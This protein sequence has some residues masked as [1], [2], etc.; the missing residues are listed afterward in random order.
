MATGTRLMQEISDQFLNCKICFESFREPKTLACLHTFCLDC[1]QQQYEQEVSSRSSRFSLYTSRSITCPLCRKK[2]ELPAGGVRRLPDNFLVCNLNQVLAK[3]TVSRVPPCDICASVRGRSVDAC[4]KCLDCTKLL[5]KECVDLHL[6]TK[7]TQQHSIIDLEGEKDIVCKVHS[8]ET[9]KF[10]CEPCGSCI[11]VVCAFQEHKDHD[12]L[13]FSDSFAK[14]RGDLESLL[15]Q[16]KTRAQEVSSRLSVIDKY[17]TVVKGVRDTIR[18]L[19][20]SSIAKVRAKERE[21][22]KR[23]DDLYGGEVQAFVDS[24]PAL[25]ENLDELQN[26]VQFT[27][28]MLR[29]KSVELLLMK[30]DIEVKMAQLLGPELQKIPSDPALY[31]IRFEPGDVVLGKLSFSGDETNDRLFQDEDNDDI[32]K[33][34]KK[35]QNRSTIPG[36]SQENVRN[37]AEADLNFKSTSSSRNGPDVVTD[38][39]Q[40]EKAR[41]QEMSTQVPKTIGDTTSKSQFKD[42]RNNTEK[43]FDTSNNRL[44]GD[45]FDTT[46]SIKDYSLGKNDLDGD[47]PKSRTRT[48]TF[49]SMGQSGVSSTYLPES[50]SSPGTDS[51]AMTRTQRR[52]ER[53]ARRKLLSEAGPDRG[54]APDLVP[55][56]IPGPPPRSPIS[57]TNTS[58]AFVYTPGRTIRSRKIQTEI[59]ALDIQ[60]GASNTDREFVQTMLQAELV[61]EKMRQEKEELTPFSSRLRDR[62]KKVRTADI[63]VMTAFEVRIVPEMVDKE[64]ASEA[65]QQKDAGMQVFSESCTN[66]TQT[67]VVRLENSGMCTDREGQTEKG[68]STLNIEL[69]DKETCTTQVMNETKATWTEGVATSDRATATMVIK[70]QHRAVGTIPQSTGVKGCQANPQVSVMYTNTPVVAS[71]DLECQVTPQ[72]SDMATMPDPDLKAESIRRDAQADSLNVTDS[73]SDFLT[74]PQSPL[75]K[76]TSTVTCDRA[77]DAIHIQTFNKFTETLAVKTVTSS[78]ETPTAKVVDRDMGTEDIKTLDQWTE[79]YTP[80]M[81]NTGVTPPRPDTL[82]VGVS[83]TVVLTD[84][85]ATCTDIKSFRDTQTET[86]LVVCDGETL[87]DP[88]GQSDAQ[89]SVE[90][91]TQSRQCETELVETADETSMTEYFNPWEAIDTIAQA[92]QCDTAILKTKETNTAQLKRKNKEAQTCS[93]PSL[94]PECGM[95]DKDSNKSENTG[96][97][98]FSDLQASKAFKDSSTMPQPQVTQDVGTMAISCNACNHDYQEMAIQTFQPQLY[99]KASATSFDLNENF[100]ARALSR[101]YHDVA[102]STDSLPFIGLLSEIDVDELIVLSDSAPELVSAS[103]DSAYMGERVIMVDDETSTDFPQ[104]VETGTQTF[105]A[106]PS[107]EESGEACTTE[108]DISGKEIDQC[109]EAL[110][111]ACF[112]KDNE[113]NGSHTGNSSICNSLSC[114]SRQD[115]HLVSIGVNT[116]PKVTFEKETCM[117]AEYLLTKNKM[118]FYT[119]KGTSTLNRVRIV[120]VRSPGMGKKTKSVDKIT[121]TSRVEQRE[122]A[123]ETEAQQVDG[124]ITE[125]ISKLRNV[126]ARLNSPNGSPNSPTIV[127]STKTGSNSVAGNEAFFGKTFGTGEQANTLHDESENTRQANVKNLLDK[128]N[129][130]LRR[131]DPSPSRKPQPITTLKGRNSSAPTSIEHNELSSCQKV[132]ASEFV[133][134]DTNA[135]NP[136]PDSAFSSKSLPRGFTSERRCGTVKMGS[137]PLSPPRLPLNRYNSAPGKIATVPSQTLLIKSSSAECK[138]GRSP[139]PRLPESS[140]EIS[141]RAIAPSVGNNVDNSSARPQAFDNKASPECSSSLAANAVGTKLQ[142]RHPLPSITETRTPSSCSDNSTS[143]LHSLG[144]VTSKHQPSGSAADEKHSSGAKKKSLNGTQPPSSINVQ[145]SSTSHLGPK[146]PRVSPKRMANISIGAPNVPSKTASQKVKDAPKSPSPRAKFSMQESTKPSSPKPTTPDVKKRNTKDQSSISSTS[147]SSGLSTNHPATTDPKRLSVQSSASSA[148]SRS[149]SGSNLLSVSMAESSSDTGSTSSRRSSKEKIKSSPSKDK[150]KNSASTETIQSNASNE[151]SDGTKPKK[152]GGI[153]FMQRF[154]SKKK[155]SSEG[156]KE[157]VVVNTKLC[158][159]TAD[160]VAALTTLPGPVAAAPTESYAHVPL[161]HPPHHYIPQLEVK[162]QSPV[163]KPSAFVYVNQRLIS[164]QQDNVEEKKANRKGKAKS[165]NILVAHKQAMLANKEDSRDKSTDTIKDLPRGEQTKGTVASDTKTVTD[166]AKSDTACSGVETSLKKDSRYASKETGGNPQVVKTDDAEKEKENPLL[167]SGK[168]AKEISK[169]K[170][171]AKK[172]EVKSA[173]SWIRGRGDKSG[174]K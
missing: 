149:P 108:N 146:S 45:S 142:K 110:T 6:G 49:A 97:T 64:T 137:Q 90:V 67:P 32:A 9:V 11:C 39:S 59:S 22:M 167:V 58:G 103:G 14:Y 60:A 134:D 87:T 156:K 68:T 151:T 23:I 20:I 81:I 44:H 31:D 123:V 169:T 17:E 8:E 107:K 15:G 63:G 126:S 92:S 121:M 33:L 21:L 3:R 161:Q 113:N 140:S 124:K 16:C 148:H 150:I 75:P 36:Q 99:D 122:V 138:L 128:T 153:G 26:T 38:C 41:T 168:E 18:D 93:D 139:S 71:V 84:D 125:C 85:Q 120:H 158:P 173:S 135:P 51:V 46:S 172:S 80:T 56:G 2:T 28:I 170:T 50:E 157:P 132:K 74:P 37:V 129:N 96:I 66:Y 155:K 79:T 91:Y 165:S 154:L 112:D 133:K 29:D 55:N 115:K 69:E 100:L 78:T 131:K 10:Y 76:P 116:V 42:N 86:A 111:F 5:C 98:T 109:S 118:A 19:A 72:T 88:V 12:V 130:V 141:P 34:K 160:A 52:A 24:R 101:E 166:A 127:A 136:K 89:T 144:S 53:E 25:Q 95:V 7:V 1:L 40:T 48:E 105:I 117:L 47:R 27:D 159:P 162:P 171:K 94:C 143:S 104:S 164:I 4:S 65:V 163:H 82:E 57:S 106:L 61:A 152:S 83:T 77:S 147:R 145:P 54:P 174:K 30:R 70:H 102:T 119:D 43:H 62:M 13:S 73:S 114:S 35:E